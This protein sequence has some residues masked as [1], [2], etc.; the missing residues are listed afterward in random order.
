MIYE[1]FNGKN[2]KQKMNEFIC[3]DEKTVSDIIW[4]LL[5]GLNHLH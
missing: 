2:L 3:L 5:H 1:I 4:K